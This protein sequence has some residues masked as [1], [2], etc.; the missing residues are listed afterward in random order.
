MQDFLNN[1]YKNNDSAADK[2]KDMKQ[3]I[4]DTA[5]KWTDSKNIIN[6]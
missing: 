6:H 3:I 1:I 2:G 5:R 4:L